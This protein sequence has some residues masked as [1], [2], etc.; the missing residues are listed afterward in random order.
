[1]V[2][3]VEWTRE[4][5]ATLN[6]LQLRKLMQNAVNAGRQDLVVLCEQLIATRPLKTSRSRSQEPHLHSGAKARADELAEMMG[7]FAKELGRQLD[8]SEETARSKSANTK[9]FVAHTL[10]DSRGRAKTGGAEKTKKLQ[11]D[12]LLSYRIGDTTVTLSVFLLLGDELENVRFQVNAPSAFIPDGVSF[13]FSGRNGLYR[14]RAGTEQYRFK[15]YPSL[16]EAL[17]AYEALV[18][19]LQAEFGINTLRMPRDANEVQ[20]AS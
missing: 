9:G 16:K 1:M 17:Y 2:K 5:L 20:S 10:V 19:K 6:D 14:P 12:R 7:A 4:R 11:F 13:E 3:A 18:R 15:D 8:L